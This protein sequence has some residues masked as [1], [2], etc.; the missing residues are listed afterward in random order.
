MG[1]E[2]EKFLFTMNSTIYSWRRLFLTRLPLVSG[3]E[4]N[5]NFY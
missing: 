1:F 5:L 3:E 2:D 4:T